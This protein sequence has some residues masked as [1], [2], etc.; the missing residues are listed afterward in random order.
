MAMGSVAKTSAALIDHLQQKDGFQSSLKP[1]CGLEQLTQSTVLAAQYY[2][3][4]TSIMYAFWCT[5][6]EGNARM[7]PSRSTDVWP[8]RYAVRRIQ[9]S[10]TMAG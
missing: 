10:S 7:F 4:I 1:F 9:G 8:A 2:T 5:P 6:M 3:S